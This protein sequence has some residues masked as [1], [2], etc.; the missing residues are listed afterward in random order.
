MQLCH[1]C[2]LDI[3]P[4]VACVELLGGLFDRTDPTF[5]IIDGEVMELAYVHRL[6]LVNGLAPSSEK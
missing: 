2:Q 4:G 3:A 5:F 1:I 6:C